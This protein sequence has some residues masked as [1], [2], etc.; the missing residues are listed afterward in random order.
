MIPVPAMV[1][2]AQSPR[3]GEILALARFWRIFAPCECDIL[4]PAMAH[5]ASARSGNQE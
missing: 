5:C 4:A 1:D 2:M 3:E